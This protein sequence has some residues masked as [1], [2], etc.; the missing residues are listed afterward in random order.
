MDRIF[1][2]GGT[3]T[4]AHNI[5]KQ[6]GFNRGEYIVVVDAQSHYMRGLRGQTLFVVGTADARSDYSC[7]VG[8]A[9]SSDFTAIY[10]DDEV[11]DLVEGD[12]S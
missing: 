8:G 10:I 11:L 12:V 9:L 5:A 6:L 4:E 2:F 1:F 3:A 7:V